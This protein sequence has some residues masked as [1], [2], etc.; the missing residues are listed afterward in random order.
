[1][2]RCKRKN[3][4]CTATIKT[5]QRNQV[6]TASSFFNH[7]HSQESEGDILKCKINSIVKKQ[8]IDKI[9]RDPLRLIL[10]ILQQ[11][12]GQ[13]PTFKDLENLKKT[14]LR[15]RQKIRP[16]LPK[17][18]EDCLIMLKNEMRV[19]NITGSNLIRRVSD[20]MVML[21]CDQ[22]LHLL[23]YHSQQL[24]S[25]GSFSFCPSFKTSNNKEDF[26]QFYTFHITKNNFYI[27]TVCFLLKDK[28]EK[29]YTKML[30]CLNEHTDYLINPEICMIDFEIAMLKSLKKT[31]PHAKIRGCHFHLTQSWIKKINKLGL[32]RHYSDANSDIGKW[33]KNV[34]ALPY[35]EPNDVPSV[36][37]KCLKPIAPENDDIAAFIAYLEKYYIFNDSQFFPP[38]IW[39]GLGTTEFKTTN[40]GAES[41]HHSLSFFFKQPHPNIYDFLDNWSLITDIYATIKSNPKSENKRHYPKKS[42]RDEYVQLCS[43]QITIA[44]YIAIVKP[45]SLPVAITIQTDEEP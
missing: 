1:M 21:A 36:F 16:A 3:S 23:S 8:A 44:A 27:P 38:S 7:N 35:F 28:S 34:F 17:T 25:D 29:S 20:D 2:W 10:Q 32:K 9:D 40:N 31:F 19:K 14:V 11:H 26:L 12:P 39:A 45:V 13:R 24:F 43:G 22:S 30:E 6:V 5:N 4:R 33:L 42:F 18:L 41:F 37:E 15:E